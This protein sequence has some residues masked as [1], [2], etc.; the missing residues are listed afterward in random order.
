MRKSCYAPIRGSFYYAPGGIEQ[1]EGPTPQCGTLDM[2]VQCYTYANST[3]ALKA[4]GS[5]HLT[6]RSTK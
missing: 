1:D 4:F 2:P 5:G 3:A 6:Y